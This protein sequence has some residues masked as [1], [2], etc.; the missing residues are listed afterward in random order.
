MTASDNFER[1]A[2]CSCGQLSIVVHASPLRISVCHC[3][4]CQRRTGS[5]FGAQ[6]RFP[7]DKVAIA[8]TST[9]YK[10]C[11]DSGGTISFNFCPNCGSTVYY[12]LEDHPDVV[13]VPVGVFADPNFPEPGVSFYE[14]RRHSW[15]S[16]PIE[17]D[18]FD[19]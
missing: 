9:E 3:L 15:A 10:R 18:R 7:S 12:T 14:A 19:D 8:G 11:G 16:V 2:T 5:V 13:V 6:A 17:A 1:K 4:E